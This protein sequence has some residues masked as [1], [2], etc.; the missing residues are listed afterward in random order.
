MTPTAVH[1]E[2]SSKDHERYV[3]RAI[4]DWAAANGIQ[5]SDRGAV[6]KTVR[7]GWIEAHQ[8]LNNEVLWHALIRDGVGT[9]KWIR[10]VEILCYRCAGIHTHGG[11][12]GAR[13]QEH[14]MPH[15]R[16]EYATPGG[17][18]IDD[19]LPLDENELAMVEANTKLDEVRVITRGNAPR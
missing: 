8:G 2:R 10:M 13:T 15:C 16:G 9:G 18:Y 5:V 6:P 1:S 7:A 11:N 17:Y 3:N 12:L 4:R 14:R 19:A